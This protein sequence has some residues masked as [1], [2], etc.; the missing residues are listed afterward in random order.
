MYIF[1]QKLQIR[2]LAGIQ[3]LRKKILIYEPEPYLSALYAHYLRVHNF[4]VKHCPSLDVLRD[5][6]EIILPDVLVFSAE[7]DKAIAWLLNFT[8]SFPNILVVTTG[9]KADSEVLKQFMSA[10]VSGHINR[11]LTRP[12]DLGVIIKSLL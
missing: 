5:E 9:F 10:G 8:K 3:S 11:R 12:Q 1:K 7:H 6:A 4:D 2:D